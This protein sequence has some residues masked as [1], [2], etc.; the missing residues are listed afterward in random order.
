MTQFIRYQAWAE[1]YTGFDIKLLRT[2]GGGKYV[3]DQFITYLSLMGIERQLTTARSPQQNGVAER[4]NRTLTKATRAM[5]PP[6]GLPFSFWTRA[7]KTTVYLRNRSPTKALTNVTPYQAWR[8]DKPDI[9]P[10]SVYSVV[11]LI[12]TWT[13]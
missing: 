4:M 5:L 9:S 11:V 1:W 2:D 10:T 8:G 3:N 6:S 7:L 13:R 12:C